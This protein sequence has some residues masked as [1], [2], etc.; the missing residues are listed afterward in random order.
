MQFSPYDGPRIFHALVDHLLLLVF[1]AEV[2]HT[3]PAQVIYHGW[4]WLLPSR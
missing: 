1:V 4:R 2:L 3:Q